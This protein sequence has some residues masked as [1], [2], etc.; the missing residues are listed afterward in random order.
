MG[1]G[2]HG[3]LRHRLSWVMMQPRHHNLELEMDPAGHGHLV[4]WSR[5]VRRLDRMTLVIPGPADGA[6]CSEFQD[7]GGVLWQTSGR[8]RE[9][10]HKLIMVLAIF[11]H[12][13]LYLQPCRHWM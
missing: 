7:Q 5:G 11:M 2:S 9:K 4:R 6:G 8:E 13:F 12:L 10:R 3:N 1:P